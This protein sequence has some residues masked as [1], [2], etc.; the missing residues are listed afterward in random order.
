MASFRLAVC[1]LVLGAAVIASCS[2]DSAEKVDPATKI[3]ATIPIEGTIRQVAV[4][5]ESHSLFVSDFEGLVWVV[6]TQTDK[7]TGKIETGDGAQGLA[8]DLGSHTL[9]VANYQVG[10]VSVIDTI[11]KK[12]TGTLDAGAHPD[13]L[14]FDSGTHTLYASHFGGEDLTAVDT[15]TKQVKATIPL[16]DYTN[17]LAID[18]GSHRLYVA[19][20]NTAKLSV[21]DT[22]SNRIDSTI[23]YGG[24]PRGVAVAPDTQRLYT[25]NA[26][27]SVTVLDAKTKQSIATMPVGEEPVHLAI[28]AAAHAAYV[29]NNDGLAKENGGDGG[30]ISVIDT[31]K[32]ASIATVLVGDSPQ[33][34][35]IDP[36][37]HKVY[38]LVFLT[39]NVTVLEP[40]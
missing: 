22:Q 18:P 39:G 31:D 20:F 8:M 1:G 15:L 3:A 37:S 10:T 40:A 29:V 9:Y 13:R 34:V 5:P 32:N 35:A 36:T 19:N 26:N 38:I 24:Q 33:A 17:D 16:G 7:V 11:D 27:G 28:D 12:V 25:A 30:P 6:D 23:E 4:D 14:A 2:T 21:I